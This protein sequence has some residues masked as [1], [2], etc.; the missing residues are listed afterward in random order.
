[1]TKDGSGHHQL[2][3]EQANQTRQGIYTG[4][5]AGLIWGVYPFIYKPLA[6]I[7]ILEVIAHRVLWSVVFL[8][9]VTL[10]VSRQGPRLIETLRSLRTVA[11]L[12]ACAGILAG[13]WLTYVYCLVSERILEAGLG[14]YLGPV[15]TAL[16]GVVFLKEKPDRGSLLAVAV[17]F[18][19]ILIYAFATQGHFPVYGLMLGLFY[20]GYTIFKRGFVRVPSQVAIT[21][22]FGLLLVPALAYLAAKGAEGTLVGFVT[23]TPTQ[24]ALLIFIGLMNVIPMWCYS[25]ASTNVPSVTMSFIQYLSPTFNFLLAVFYYREPFGLPSLI[26]FLLVWTGIGIFIA[27]K[28]NRARLARN[29]ASTSAPVATTQVARLRNPL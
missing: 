11:L 26:M 17:S 18:T 2:Q 9:P 21:I 25:Y 3:S 16:M 19:G 14:Y 29:G 27:N 12:T 4:I 28:L 10:L 8:L 6:S 22:E 13:W 5:A 23:T 1:M 15:L 24:T 20:A 7:D